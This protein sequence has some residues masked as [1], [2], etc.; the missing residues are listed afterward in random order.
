MVGGAGAGGGRRQRWW[1]C[2]HKLKTK[3]PHKDV[4][5]KR[6]SLTC[7]FVDDAH[8]R[9]LEMFLQHLRTR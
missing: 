6:C 1:R 4:G 8:A 9:V 5:S 2:E 7:V 3:T